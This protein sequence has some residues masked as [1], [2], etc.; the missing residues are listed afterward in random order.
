MMRCDSNISSNS[1]TELIPH[2]CTLCGAN[3]TAPKC[4]MHQEKLAPS[5]GRTF[6]ASISSF[7]ALP[8]VTLEMAPQYVSGMI[9]GLMSFFPK[10]FQGWR[11]LQQM[12]MPQCWRSCKQ[13][14]SMNFSSCRSHNKHFKNMKSYNCIY[15]TCNMMLMPKIVGCPSGAMC[16]L[17]GVSTPRFLVAWKRTQYSKPFGNLVALHV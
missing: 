10:S 7:E 16:I 14:T 8:N 9:Y 3:I 13:Q 17:R 1:T 5:G 6:F 11:P 2:G 12:R 4:P 15:R